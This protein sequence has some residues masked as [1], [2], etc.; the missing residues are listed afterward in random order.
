MLIV[1]NIHMKKLL[2]SISSVAMYG[3]PAMVLAQEDYTNL[4]LNTF[5]T[6]TNLGTNIALIAAIA[7][8]INI[9]LGFLGVI[10]VILILWGGFKW[11]TAAGDEGKIDEAKKLMGGGVVGLVIILAAYAIAS[12]VVNQLIGATSYNQP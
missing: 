7:R 3:L 1:N 9:L 4:G 10:A 11:M 8:I 2:V 6:E 5:A 12:F